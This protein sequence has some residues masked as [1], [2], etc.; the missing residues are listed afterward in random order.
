MWKY[1]WSLSSFK[2][3][4]FFEQ[5]SFMR[6]K[7]THRAKRR[8]TLGHSKGQIDIRSIRVKT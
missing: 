4:S 2:S 7:G 6:A 1:F 3:N 5:I 8:K